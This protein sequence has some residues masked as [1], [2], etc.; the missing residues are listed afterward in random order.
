MN[1]PWDY[2]FPIREHGM[3]Y[4]SQPLQPHE[5]DAMKSNPI[6]VERIVASYRLM[7]DFYGM[8]LVSLETGLIDR[9]LPPRNY[10]SRYHNLVRKWNSIRS[11]IHSN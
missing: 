2:R 3:N 4:E 1:A 8:R 5:I 11:C 10:L 7:L 6:I 9:S